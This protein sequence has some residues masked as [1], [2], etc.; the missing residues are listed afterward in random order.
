[1]AVNSIYKVAI[2]GV[3]GF[4]Q[5]LVTTL[6][7][8]AE[9][10]TI[11]DTQAEDLA[12]AIVAD[13]VPSFRD[14]F[15]SS[16]GVLTIQVRGVTD[17]TE[18]F[19]YSYPSLQLGSRGGDPLPPQAAGVITWT[20]GRV[21]R[22]FRG[23]AFLWAAGEGDQAGGA[24]TPTYQAIMSAF[25]EAAQYIGDGIAT[26]HYQQVVYSRKFTLATPINGHV[27]RNTVYTQRRRVSGVGS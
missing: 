13:V 23:R 17:P 8:R 5:D 24:F 3:G 1:M 14:T 4:S 7:Y 11:F 15:N 21:G 16:S 19:D 6:H 2:V 26:S 18:G 27:V 22:R 10:A 25:A 12:Q 20:T 9:D